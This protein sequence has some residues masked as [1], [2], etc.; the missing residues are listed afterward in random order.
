MKA[1]DIMTTPVITV[2]P[3][4]PVLNIAALLLAR[5]ISAVPVV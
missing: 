4:T 3:D 1:K 5:Q 2:E